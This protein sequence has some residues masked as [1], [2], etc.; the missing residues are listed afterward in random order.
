MNCKEHLPLLI[1]LKLILHSVLYALRKQCSCL[2]P[3]LKTSQQAAGPSRVTKLSSEI[4]SQLT[5]VWLC[6]GLE[7]QTW[8]SSLCLNAHF[9]NYIAPVTIVGRSQLQFYLSSLVVIMHVCPAKN[10]TVNILRKPLHLSNHLFVCLSPTGMGAFKLCISL[11]SPSLSLSHFS[12]FSPLFTQASL[13]LTISLSLS[14]S[15]LLVAHSRCFGS[16]SSSRR[17]RLSSCLSVSLFVFLLF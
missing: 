7:I 9:F 3:Q 16:G 15:R 11:F 5:S 4:T 13:C 12:S 6:C 10:N 17:F 14:L 8:N 2:S 1:S